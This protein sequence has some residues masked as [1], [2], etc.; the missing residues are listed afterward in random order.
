LRSLLGSLLVLQV[1]VATLA[2]WP[3]L[4]GRRY[5]AYLDIGSDSYTQFSA[6]AMSLARLFGREGWTGWS[7]EIGLGAPVGFV[8]VD[9]FR[10]LTQLGGADHVLDLRIWVFLL[11]LVLGG[12]FF[13]LMARPLV[14]RPHAA[15][16]AAVSYSFCGYM[17]VNGTWDS[18]TNAFVF[19][20]L[21]LWA[22]IRYIR[23]GNLVVIPIA[24]G[25]ATLSGVFIVST[26][27]SLMLAGA[28]AVAISPS[29]RHTL[30]QW[31][32][33]VLP[34]VMLGF[35][36]G[37]PTALPML[38][39]LLDSPRVMGGSVLERFMGAIVISDP[40]MVLQQLSAVFHK[41]LLGSGNAY[42]GYMNYLEGPGFFVGLL[43]LLLL[44]Q[45]WTASVADR[46]CLLVGLAAIAIYML[47][48]AIR[49]SAFGFAAPY[50]RVTTLWVTIG[51]LLLGMRGLD[52]LLEQ[53]DPR[54][55]VVGAACVA[56]LLAVLATLLWPVIWQAYLWKL[57]F[58]LLAWC[59][60]MV[61]AAGRWVSPARLAGVVVVLTALEC[62]AT[63]VPSMVVG[64]VAATPDLQ[65]FRDETLEAL[66]TI[67]SRDPG[68]YRIEKT[69]SSFSQTDAAAQGYMGVRSYYYHGSAVY[70]LHQN[71]RML[72]NFGRHV[73][74]NASNWLEGPGDRAILHSVLGVR[75]VISR[76]P[77]Q[78]PGFEL[79]YSGRGWRAYRNRLALPL[80]FVQSRQVVREDMAALDGVPADRRDWMRD[81]LLLN[82]V[83]LD[84]LL[85]DM[86]TRMDVRSLASKP[87]V[88]LDT[89][90]AEPALA[91]QATGL[92]VDSFASDHITGRVHPAEAGL[93]VFSIPDYRGWS[94][95]I[96][97]K[98]TTLLRANFG[99]LAAPVQAGE[100]RVS[101]RFRLPGLVPGMLVGLLAALLI[102]ALRHKQAA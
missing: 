49:L 66:A 70:D 29:P 101:L 47:L 93:L 3:F 87:V 2:L 64:R 23:T 91:L 40:G 6:F 96:D 60:V 48:P 85:P 76:E 8:F 44:P 22:V 57:A 21:I 10:F 97:G 80:G 55:V 16:V 53:P 63:V 69:Y 26:G 28:C 50:F 99:M 9:M 88:D 37:A 43:P 12:A 51:L 84:S 35:A 24:V 73:P 54:M 15:L 92:Q 32:R 39:Q 27:V 31:L 62:V 89:A 13:L 77:L 102:L 90:Y 65:P 86:G 78:W 79:A 56:G 83:V 25:A 38:S 59:A 17:V 18:E 20:P 33:G 14:Q 30:S 4:S 72:P 5:L 81:L 7:F 75:Y 46:R 82:A 61:L 52:R 1:L 68:V 98:P 94:L 67:R 74:V 58:F 34:L 71:L 19:F 42:R 36:L 100:H 11:K 95:E 45:L 41:D